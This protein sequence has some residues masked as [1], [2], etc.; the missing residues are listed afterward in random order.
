MTLD[1]DPGRVDTY[2][3]LPSHLTTITHLTTPTHPLIECPPPPPPPPY[4]NLTALFENPTGLTI[5]FLTI[6]V[7]CYL[8]VYL[9]KRYEIQERDF[10]RM[11]GGQQQQQ[12]QQGQGQQGEQEGNSTQGLKNAEVGAGVEK[13]RYGGGVWF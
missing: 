9:P 11:G 4:L 10:R 7:G 12:Q 1:D 13:V 2:A 8:F 5:T 3:Y 6:I